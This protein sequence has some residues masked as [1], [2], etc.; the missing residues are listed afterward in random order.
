MRL[1]SLRIEYFFAL[2]ICCW[3][4]AIAL[5][6]GLLTLIVSPTSPVLHLL[7]SPFFLSTS[8]VKARDRY[9]IE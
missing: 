7:V 9:N 4:S 6:D 3:A 1:I 8:S 2:L 5:I